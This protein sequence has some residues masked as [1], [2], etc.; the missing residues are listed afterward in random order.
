VHVLNAAD[1]VDLVHVQPDVDRL[2]VD[3]AHQRALV[4]RRVNPVERVE[5]LHVNDCRVVSPHRDGVGIGR[6]L[7]RVGFLLRV[8]HRETLQRCVVLERDE[9]RAL[10]YHENALSG[11]GELADLRGGQ[12]IDFYCVPKAFINLREFPE[13]ISFFIR[14]EG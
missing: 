5:Q 11:R 9:G 4:L 13:N 12:G 2:P 14:T 8:V 6:G 7:G 3:V 10:L 1:V